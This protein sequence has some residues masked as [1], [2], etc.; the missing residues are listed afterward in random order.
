MVSVAHKAAKK[1]DAS[2]HEK[3]INLLDHDPDQ[4]SSRNSVSMTSTQLKLL[5]KLE[6]DRFQEILSGRGEPSSTE[7]ALFE[8]AQILEND[9]PTSY[10]NLPLEKDAEATQTKKPNRFEDSIHAPSHPSAPR[11]KIPSCHPESPGISSLEIQ[12]SST[13]SRGLGPVLKSNQEKYNPMS[14]FD[15]KQ[16]EHYQTIENNDHGSQADTKSA[17]KIDMANDSGSERN[18]N[19]ASERD[20][21]VLS[22]R[23]HTDFDP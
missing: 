13:I 19:V 9:K 12:S 6:P 20:R 22:L 7:D 1:G 10:D 21:L 16:K 23:Q 3:G 14:Y 2:G 5:R 8:S 11:F 17:M 15:V 4:D 18:E